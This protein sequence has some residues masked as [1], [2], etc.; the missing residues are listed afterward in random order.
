MRKYRFLG[1]INPIDILLIV[2]AVL[3]IW[4]AYLLA[5]PQNVA[6]DGSRLIRFTFEMGERPAGFYQTIEIGA[7][8]E[9]GSQNWWVGEI[10]NTYALPFMADATDERAGIVRRRPVEGLEFTYVVIEAWANISDASTTIGDFW[11][12]VN[13][14]VPLRSRDFAGFGFITNIEIVQ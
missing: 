12:A 11:V 14:H 6:A 10:V 1:I 2:A 4:G 7:P 5:Q 8:V 13:R 3:L 9:Y